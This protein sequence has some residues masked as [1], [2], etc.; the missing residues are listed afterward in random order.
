MFA[1]GMSRRRVLGGAL[2]AMGAAML[3]GCDTMA[4]SETIPGQWHNGRLYIATGNTTGVFYQVGGGYADIISAH[5]SGFTATAEPTS[6]A[7]ENIRRV[8]RGDADIA[9]TYADA[10]AD[11]VI[12]RA[13]FAGAVQPIQAIARIY[14]GYT[15]V[16]ARTAANITTMA[17]LAGKKVSTSSPG[18]GTEYLALRLLTAAGI[19]PDHGV[20]RRPLSLLESVKAMKNGT[21]DALFFTAGLPTGGITDLMSSMHDGVT[22]LPVAELLP[23]LKNVYGTAYAPATIGRAVYGLKADVPTVSVETL[24]VVR[25][26]MPEPL[27]YDLTRVLFEYQNELAKAH[28]EGKNLNRDTAWLVDPVPLQPGSRRYLGAPPH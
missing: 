11:A 9:L 6:A 22:F 16:I 7:V 3:A 1:T 14:T 19:D 10:A 17:D 20:T 8:A 27:G 5:L 2:G 21:I 25:N 13:T 24:I 12:G 26:D 18:S 15:H 23:A 28:P 4:E